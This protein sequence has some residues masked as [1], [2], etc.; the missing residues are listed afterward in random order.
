MIHA[1]WSFIATVATFFMMIYG[2]IGG[3]NFNDTV[4]KYKENVSTVEAYSNTLETAVP[5]T[6]IYGMIKN[7][8]P[9]GLRK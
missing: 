6:D 8:Y 1:F 4:K 5:Q 9:K 3:I 2:L 7:H